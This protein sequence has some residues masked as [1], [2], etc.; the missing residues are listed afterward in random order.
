MPRTPGR[1]RYSLAHV[2][3]SR[4]GFRVLCAVLALA[5]CGGSS[6]APVAKSARPTIS[7]RCSNPGARSASA[8]RERRADYR[9]EAMASQQ[10]ACG[11]PATSRGD[12]SVGGPCHNGSITRSCAEM[13]GL[14]FDHR[15]RNRGRTIQPS[16]RR[17][18]RTKAINPLVR[19]TT[20]V[21]SS[22]RGIR[23]RSTPR[24]SRRSARG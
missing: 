22:T 4:Q 7:S 6:P 19:A 11:L 13:N 9:P 18:S 14:D 3:E 24:R 21:A 16:T 2:R 17:F 5:G 23:F 8:A 12:R 1:R 15:V 10:P 20:R